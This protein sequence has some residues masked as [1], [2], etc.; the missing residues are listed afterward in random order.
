MTKF[1]P[2]PDQALALR[3]DAQWLARH[4]GAHIKQIG[5]FVAAAKPSFRRGSTM[6]WREAPRLI[7]RM[8]RRGVFAALY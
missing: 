7:R 4:E 1:S 8:R 5:R 3:A 6:I 2:A